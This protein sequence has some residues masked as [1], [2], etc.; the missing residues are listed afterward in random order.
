MGSGRNNLP[1]QEQSPHEGPTSWDKE[2]LWL[3]AIYKKN[4]TIATCLMSGLDRSPSTRHLSN[5]KAEL[6][7]SQMD[8]YTSTFWKKVIPLKDTSISVGYELNSP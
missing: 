6:E 3:Y 4:T 2:D 5:R 1:F 7:N 8:P